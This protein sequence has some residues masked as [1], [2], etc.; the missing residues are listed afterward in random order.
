MALLRRA[1][2]ALEIL[3]DIDG[4]G[5]PDPGGLFED[6]EKNWPNNDGSTNID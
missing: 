4:N 5:S 1:V 6:D 3:A 2:L